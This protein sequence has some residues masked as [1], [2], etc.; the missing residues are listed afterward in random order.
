ML[1]FR[2]PLSHDLAFVMGLTSL[3]VFYF[4]TNLFSS[5]ALVFPKDTFLVGPTRR[6]QTHVNP[7]RG[8]SGDLG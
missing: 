6:T 5:D 8:H 7:C 4:R 3:T 2:L 1:N